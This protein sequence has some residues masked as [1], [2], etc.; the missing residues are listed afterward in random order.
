MQPLL[1]NQ[2][3]FY[4]VPFIATLFS[5]TTT[6]P[7]QPSCSPSTTSF[8]PPLI[9]PSHILPIP[10]NFP[11]FTV[12]AAELDYVLAPTLRELADG[13]FYHTPDK[14]KD[15]EL[16]TNLQLDARANMEWKNW[17]GPVFIIPRPCVDVIW[18]LSARILVEFFKTLQLRDAQ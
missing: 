1:S 11:P 15:D 14:E 18:G 6:T 2:H 17:K 10:P 7:I 8:S 12:Q 4:V 5:N 9:V 16:V 13:Y 3:K